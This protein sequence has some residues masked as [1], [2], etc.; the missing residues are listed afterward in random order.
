MFERKA[1]IKNYT[2]LNSVLDFMLKNLLE[3]KFDAM[4]V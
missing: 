4:W 1:A 2:V 3:A